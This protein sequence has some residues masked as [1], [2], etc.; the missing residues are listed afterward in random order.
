MTEL[1]DLD[2]T[3]FETLPNAIGKGKIQIDTTI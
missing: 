2:A 3:I 1:S